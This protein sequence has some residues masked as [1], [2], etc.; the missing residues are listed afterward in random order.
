MGCISKYFWELRR[1]R[2]E[3]RCSHCGVVIKPGELYVYYFGVESRNPTFGFDRTP[4]LL[5]GL[6]LGS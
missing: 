3:Y 6:R 4:H 5:S 2:K 1:A